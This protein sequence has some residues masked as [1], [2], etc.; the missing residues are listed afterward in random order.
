MHM[1]T[2]ELVGCSELGKLECGINT[3]VIDRRTGRH[4]TKI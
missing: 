3:G 4:A 1:T 2:L